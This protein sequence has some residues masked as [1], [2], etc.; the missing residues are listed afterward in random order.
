M[1]LRLDSNQR[2]QFQRLI[3]L[4]H[5]TTQ[6]LKA[7]R[8]RIELMS[9]D[10]QSGMLAV[11]P[12]NHLSSTRDSN[13]VILIGS[14][15]RRHQRLYCIWYRRQDSNLYPPRSKRGIQPIG[16]LLCLVAKNQLLRYCYARFNGNLFNFFRCGPARRR[17]P[18]ILLTIDHP[19][20]T[21]FQ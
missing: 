3:M 1:L 5:Y 11:T 8:M 13:S 18:L 10:R 17:E 14:Q 15:A 6:Q 4:N 2:H 21:I 19:L 9:S 12:T 20:F 7:V 16:M